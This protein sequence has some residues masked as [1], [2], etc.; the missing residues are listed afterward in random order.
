MHA[1]NQQ[2]IVKIQK[3]TND[4]S[5]IIVNEKNNWAKVVSVGE[6]CKQDLKEGDLV[7]IDDKEGREY[8]E[9]LIINE[10]HILCVVK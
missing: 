5:L 6:S 4:N 7:F 10:D 1:V 9:V 2:V 3:P 8:N